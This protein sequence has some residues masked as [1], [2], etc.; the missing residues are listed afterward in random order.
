M[1]PKRQEVETTRGLDPSQ[2][3][4]R[5][6]LR[7]LSI[8]RPSKNFSERVRQNW[9]SSQPPVSLRV[10]W[11]AGGEGVLVSTASPESHLKGFGPMVLGGDSQCI[12]QEAQGQIILHYAM[13][14]QPNV[15]LEDKEGMKPPKAAQTPPTVCSPALSS[16]TLTSNNA[17]SG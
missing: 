13:E 4:P 3:L 9:V 6:H 2:E 5:N 17:I 15:V 11:G 10:C 1:G 14:H 12:L 8:G 7:A 16:P